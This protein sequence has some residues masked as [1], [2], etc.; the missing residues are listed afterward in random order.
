MVVDEWSY[1][2]P[3]P[4]QEALIQASLLGCSFW[5]QKVPWPWVCH[6][7]HRRRFLWML[8]GVQVTSFQSQN[9]SPRVAV[10]SGGVSVTREG[11][12]RL[13][14][15]RD[16]EV[17][18][19][20]ASL[21]I[22]LTHLHPGSVLINLSCR[23][24]YFMKRENTQ[25]MILWNWCWCAFHQ[26]MFSQGGRCNVFVEAGNVEDVIDM[27]PFSWEIFP[28]PLWEIWGWL[29]TFIFPDKI[30][31]TFSSGKGYWSFGSAQE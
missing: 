2:E 24:G 6:S 31:Q 9:H 13:S 4:R 29:Q 26:G 22:S 30:T 3:S 12:R 8:S 17:W 11:P 19:R 21:W 16:W 5:L 7:K 15:D 27:I 20:D 28:S 18:I 23:A 25:L 14:S 1:R 10:N